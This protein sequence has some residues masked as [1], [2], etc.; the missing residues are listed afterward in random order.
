MFI[1]VKRM[2]TFGRRWCQT[3]GSG[4]KNLFLKE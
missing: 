4:V 2:E 3:Y 1:A